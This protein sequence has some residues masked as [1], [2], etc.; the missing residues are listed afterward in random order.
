MD[1]Q[2]APTSDDLSDVLEQIKSVDKYTQTIQDQ[3]KDRVIFNSSQLLEKLSLVMP[4]TDA[5]TQPYDMIMITPNY[6][7]AINSKNYIKVELES[8]FN[9]TSFCVD[10]QKLFQTIKFL[11]SQPI[12]L[13]ID[14]VSKKVE[15]LSDN[16][17]FKLP[18]EN[19]DYLNEFEANCFENRQTAKNS[20]MVKENQI[21]PHL[22]NLYGFC[23]KND[24]NENMKGVL[25][26]NK[27]SICSFVATDSH[28]IKVAK[29]K[30]KVIDFSFLLPATAAENLCKLAS[31]EQERDIHISYDSEYISF[32]F[33]GVQFVCKLIDETFPDYE[34]VLPTEH[35]ISITASRHDLLKCLKR[36]PIFG[37]RISNRLELEID[38]NH[39]TVTAENVDFGNRSSERFPI[40]SNKFEFDDEF[41]DGLRIGINAKFFEKVLKSFD[42][43]Y[44]ELQFND[45][46][47]FI[48]FVGDKEKS[49]E[50]A[51]VCPLNLERRKFDDD[52]SSDEEE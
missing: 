33:G 32:S 8:E 26:E 2:N 23:G 9:F 10:A 29:E 28:I 30:I 38:N 39:I 25:V 46:E 42:C 16:G 50:M 24:F 17:R 51:I 49:W 36:V 43:D 37:N 5:K 31:K 11:P 6:I 4:T 21:F 27:D 48:E 14:L 44:I 34:K 35:L 3:Q 47:K 13:T 18:I 41:E 22:K 12:T 45:S 19:A 20:F 40:K 52:D 1:Y 7:Q 15:I